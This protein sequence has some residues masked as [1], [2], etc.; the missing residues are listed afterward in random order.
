MLYIIESHYH[1]C[2]NVNTQNTFY[3]PRRYKDDNV[4]ILFPVGFLTCLSSH[5]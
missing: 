3:T 2:S 5:I 1:S 4:E